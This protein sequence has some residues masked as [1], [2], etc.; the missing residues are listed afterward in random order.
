MAIPIRV[1]QDM[2]LRIA[3]SCGVSQPA[4]SRRAYTVQEYVDWYNSH[5]LSDS[6]FEWALAKWKDEFPMAP[7]TRTK[8]EAWITEDTRES[9]KTIG[10]DVAKRRM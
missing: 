9:K 10:A 6:D 2:V 3:E 7:H 8:I 5:S 4:E 1:R